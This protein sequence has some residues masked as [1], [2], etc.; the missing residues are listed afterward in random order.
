MFHWGIFSRLLSIFQTLHSTG[1]GPGPS[2]RLRPLRLEAAAQSIVPPKETW[3]IYMPYELE[4]VSHCRSPT[5]LAG[6][7]GHAG[8]DEPINVC[9]QGQRHVKPILDSNDHSTNQKLPPTT[10]DTP[11]LRTRSSCFKILQAFSEPKGPKLESELLR[12]N[13]VTPC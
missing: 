7:A 13:T 2:I 10:W 8:A 1:N 11:P 12:H 9:Q 6:W 4:R 3:G 5:L